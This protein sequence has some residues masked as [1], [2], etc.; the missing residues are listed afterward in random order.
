MVLALQTAKSGSIR[1]TIYG[2]LR[3]TRVNLWALMGVALPQKMFRVSLAL[4]YVHQPLSH[5]Q[6]L[7][8]LLP[9]TS[10][11]TASES[12]G[13]RADVSSPDSK[14]VVQSQQ[15]RVLAWEQEAACPQTRIMPFTAHPWPASP[16][17]PG[18]EASSNRS[19]FLQHSSLEYFSGSESVLSSLFHMAAGMCLLF[20][21]LLL[22]APD[23][24]V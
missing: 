19:P 23:F 10:M 20:L 1:G 11:A 13:F 14:H 8:P 17:G 15:E 3:P 7:S 16:W 21:L 12:L 4:L 22:H 24:P 6:K 18:R 5:H 9:G 2:P